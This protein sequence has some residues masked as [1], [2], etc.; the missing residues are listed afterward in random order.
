MWTKAHQCHTQ[1]FLLQITKILKLS[2]ASLPEPFSSSVAEPQPQYYSL[3]L[4]TQE[5]YKNYIYKYALTPSSALAH[6]AEFT[7]RF[8]CWPRILQTSYKKTA[9]FFSPP[10]YQY[11]LKSWNSEVDWTQTPNKGSITRHSPAFRDKQLNIL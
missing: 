1:P 7:G 11:I 4:E 3:L 6:A 5:S 2:Q 9:T 8:L 10:I